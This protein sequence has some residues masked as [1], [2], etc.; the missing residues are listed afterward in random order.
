[1]A[2]DGKDIKF[3]ETLMELNQVVGEIVNRTKDLVSQQESKGWTKLGISE[4]KDLIHWMDFQKYFKLIH[5]ELANQKEL[6]VEAYDVLGP[7]VF[8]VKPSVKHRSIQKV[9]NK[10][11]DLHLPSLD[12]QIEYASNHIPAFQFKSHAMGKE[13]EHEI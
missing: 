8:Y 7:Y 2:E 6:K 9:S 4:F 1:M 5:N 12:T 10:A 3:I 13:L 11:H